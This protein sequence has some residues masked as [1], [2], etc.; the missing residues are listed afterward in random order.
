[1]EMEKNTNFTSRF[2]YVE[3]PGLSLIHSLG[4]LD[5]WNTP[6]MRDRCFPCKVKEGK[7]MQQGA[8]YM[9]TCITCKLER[10]DSR[11][12]GETARTPYDRGLDHWNAF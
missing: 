11:Y 6:C 3:Q 5:P 8:C 4:T 9:I 2:K 12:F 10:R 1:M 7:C